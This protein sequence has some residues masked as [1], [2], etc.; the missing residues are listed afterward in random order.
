[1]ASRDRFWTIIDAAG[2]CSDRYSIEYSRAKRALSR[3]STLEVVAFRRD[4]EHR[5]RELAQWN[6]WAVGSLLDGHLSPEFALNYFLWIVV[7]GEEFYRAVLRDPRRVLDRA[8]VEDPCFCFSFDC[9]TYLPGQI[10]ESRMREKPPGL[11]SF[12]TQ[13]LGGKPW[14]WQQLREIHPDLWERSF[15]GSDRRHLCLPKKKIDDNEFVW[16]TVEPV[17]SW[18]DIYD[19][20]QYL[21]TQ[22]AS[23]NRDQ[24]CLHAVWWCHVECQN[25]GMHQFFSNSTGVVAPEALEGFERFGA[26]AHHKEFQKIMTSFPRKEPSRDRKIRQAQLRRRWPTGTIDEEF[27]GARLPELEPILARYIRAHPLSFFRNA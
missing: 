23:L 5:V 4:L 20:D 17:S 18:V 19:G 13:K 9:L 26:K 3:F 24:V 1:M 14:K 2:K 16:H 11:D 8:S 10:A 22:Y 25:G 6:Q 12:G 7:Q 15:H 27:P 21:L